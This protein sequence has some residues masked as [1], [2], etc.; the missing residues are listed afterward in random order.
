M[1]MV[2]IWDRRRQKVVIQCGDGSDTIGATIKSAHTHQNGGSEQEDSI[3]QR[4]QTEQPE[5]G[6]FFPASAHE[7]S[8]RPRL[9]FVCI[10]VV[11][12]CAKQGFRAE[13]TRIEA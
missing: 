8:V 2:V 6:S 9:L 4:F 3:L 5:F 7:P 1:V 12:R 13:V 10:R 11:H